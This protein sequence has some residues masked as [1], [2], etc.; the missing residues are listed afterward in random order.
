MTDRERIL[1]EL[2]KG[3][4]TSFEARVNGW[5][6]NPSQR[7]NELR[8]EGHVIDAEDFYRVTGDKKRPCTRYT[9][10]REASVARAAADGAG[11][12]HVRP[13]LGGRNSAENGASQSGSTVPAPGT[14]FE[15]EPDRPVPS[16][17]DLDQREAA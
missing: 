4:I 15:L 1:A 2:R 16:Y 8:V 17:I 13:T 11:R 9:L 10:V 14:L 12:A 6:G 7:I 3:P 5:S